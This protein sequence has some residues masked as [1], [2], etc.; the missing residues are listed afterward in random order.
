M[1]AKHSEV[2]RLFRFP[3]HPPFQWILLRV[4]LIRAI[5]SERVQRVL[6]FWKLKA[7]KMLV[8]I[9]GITGN[10]GTHL[11]RAALRQGFPVRGLGRHLD[12]LDPEIASQLESF[13]TSA[14]YDDVPAL[15]KAVASVDA[16]I[17]AYAP[18]PILDLEGHLLL[19]RAAERA[20]VKIFHASSW[21][22]D[23]RK[24]DFGEFE[25]YNSHISF[26]QHVLV[27]SSIKP[28]YVYTGVFGEAVLNP[29]SSWMPSKDPATGRASAQVW[30]RGDATVS[31]TSMKDA[32]E[33]SIRLLKREDVQG[34]KGGY[35][36]VKSGDTTACDV[37]ETYRRTTGTPVDIE[38]MGSV[39]DL[40]DRVEQLRR[41]H[42]PKEYMQY[43]GLL[44]QW[45][46]VQGKVKLEDADIPPNATKL[47][48][49][50]ITCL[51]K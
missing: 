5:L 25:H 17:C 34:G 9:A 19:L 47:E 26:H 31:W 40:R 8:L 3:S 23:W 30:G 20:G 27:S 51:S 1:H 46:A 6:L 4:V 10:L 13:V 41:E 18:I 15:D 2:S 38:Q 36:S 11:A 50:L 14:G 37:A 39:D 29:A 22:C 49:L 16:V 43:I 48:E 24:F 21:N 28:V 33:F 7:N 35:F 45:F 44:V 12:N 42:G 32:A